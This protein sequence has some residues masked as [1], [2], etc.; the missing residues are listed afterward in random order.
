M[1]PLLLKPTVKEYLWGGDRLKTEFGLDCDTDVAA[2]GWML[3]CHQ[4]GP[5][6]VINGTYAGMTLSETLDRFGQC[7]LGKNAARFPYFPLLIKLI[8]AKQSL[9]VQVHPNDEYALEHEGE[10]GK[11]EMW[12]V[13]DCDEGAELI[14]GFK[15]PVTKEELKSRI[16]Q[17]T[18]T[19][20][21]NRVP[22]H[23]GDV[24]FI[25]AGTLHAI[26]GGILIAEVQQNSN[27]TYRV[28]DY[29]RVGADGNPRPLHVE[30]ALDVTL[31]EPPALPFGQVGEVTVHGK[32]TVRALAR[33]D[34]FSADLITLECTMP[35][36]CMDS[37]VSIV[38]LDGVATISWDNEHLA[39]KK[40]D[41]VFVPA[42]LA[43]EL[44]GTAKLLYSHI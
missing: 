42:G 9:S 32:N 16:E 4:D 44:N 3:S 21:C 26:G 40:G 6:T 23:K 12:Y 30:K 19:D 33:C 29:G 35:V 18:L 24:F 11:T 38:C 41:S 1:Y 8:D 39:I 31:R 5:C 37:F 22:V 25:S 17:N 36:Q 27:A 28:Y 10:F 13:V 2:E 7:A 15:E 14:Y 20:I 43:V 34:L